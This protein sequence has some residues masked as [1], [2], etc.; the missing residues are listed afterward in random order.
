[1]PLT[2]FAGL[3]DF[4]VDEVDRARGELQHVGE[5]RVL[6]FRIDGT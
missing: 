1:M 6:K 2:G 5:P 3:R 4:A